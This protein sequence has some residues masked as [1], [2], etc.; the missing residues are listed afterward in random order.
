M[1]L[2]YVNVVF[3]LLTALLPHKRLLDIQREFIRKVR[4]GADL[5]GGSFGL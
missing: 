4:Q 5:P 1:F 3:F 2:G